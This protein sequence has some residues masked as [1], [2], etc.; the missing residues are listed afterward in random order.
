VVGAAGWEQQLRTN[1]EEFSRRWVQRPDFLAEFPMSMNSNEFIDKLA[2][3]LGVAPLAPFE[4]TIA[5]ESYTQTVEGRAATLRNVIN[6][7]STYNAQF[8][9]GFVLSQYIGYLRRNPNDA[10]DFDYTGFDYW[11][12][13]MNSFSLPGEDVSNEQTAIARVRRAEMVRAFILSLEYR[14]RFG[15]P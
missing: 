5:N 13:K 11:L 7:N 3:N 6:L 8:N 14:G 10:P 2:A 12:A 15:Q 1:Q 9:P 4:R